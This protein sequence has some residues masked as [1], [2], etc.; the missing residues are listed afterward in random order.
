MRFEEI[1]FIRIL[2]EF[3]KLKRRERSDEY[4]NKFDEI[5]LSFDDYCKIFNYFLNSLPQ[6][7]GEEQIHENRLIISEWLKFSLQLNYK[8]ETTRNGLIHL[9]FNFIG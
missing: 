2:F 9:M 4:L 5:E 6:N 8:E 3:S 1:L 7:A